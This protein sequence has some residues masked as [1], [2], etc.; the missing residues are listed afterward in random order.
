MQNVK[1]QP[2]PSDIESD[3]RVSHIHIKVGIAAMLDT[4]QPGVDLIDYLK[5]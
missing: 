2:R 4:S 1:P 3:P 5:K